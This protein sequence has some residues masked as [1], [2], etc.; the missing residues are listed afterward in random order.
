MRVLRFLKR[1]LE[2]LLGCGLDVS[3]GIDSHKWESKMEILGHL[4]G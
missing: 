2:A 3:S 4:H 1:C